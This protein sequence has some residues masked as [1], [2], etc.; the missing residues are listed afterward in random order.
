M[1]T[2]IV[3][4]DFSE[5]SYN[6]ARYALGLARQ[7]NTARIVLY[8]AYELIVPIPDVPSSVPMVNPDELRSASLEGLDK[9]MRELEPLLPENTILASRAEN[10]LLPANIDQVAKQEEA[11]LIVM[12]ITGGSQL[13][14]I[15]VG[16]NT[17]DVV[18]HTTCP[19]I[20]VP[21]S[22][23]FR[24]IRKIVF[25]CDFRKVVETT[26]VQPLKKLLNVFKPELHV[27]NIDHESKHFTSDTPYETLMLDTLLEGYDPQFHFIDHTNV[28]Q[29]IMDF[30]ARQEADLILIIPKKHGLFDH[31]FKRS[32]TTQLAFHTHVPLL[33]I[34]E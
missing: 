25:A 31:I 29:G 17:V 3:P 8:H 7:M 9:M 12:G 20:I 33:A 34:H 15:L 16:S 23:R 18:K 13:E 10:H 19:V 6:A 32:R 28:V 11:D 5:T 22:A 14:E 30:A 4:T 1:K 21:G 27:L 26:P 2:I 24:P